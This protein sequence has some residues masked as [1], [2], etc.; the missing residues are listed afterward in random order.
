[1]IIQFI[2]SRIKYH[3][4]WGNNGDVVEILPFEKEKEQ[5]VCH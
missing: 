5:W 3:D 1:M 4:D 2:K